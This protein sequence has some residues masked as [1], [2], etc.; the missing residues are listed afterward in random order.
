[1]A[2]EVEETMK[3]IQS[4]K[5]VVGTIVVN[6]EGIP[7]KSTLDNTTTVQYAGLISQLSDKARSVVRDLDPTNDLTFLRIRSKKHEI[8][9]APDKEFILIVIQNPVD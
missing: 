4:H 3:R 9:V 7:I 1:M 2:Q 6:G 8:M 5:G